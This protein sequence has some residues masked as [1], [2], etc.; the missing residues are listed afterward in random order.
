[1]SKKITS[2]DV[3]K[4]L[5]VSRSAVSRAF[6]EGASIHPEKRTLILEAAKALGYQ[7]NFFARN[8]S[9]P[10][11]KAKSNLIVILISDF[12]NPFQ[13]FLFE[14]L[15]TALQQAGKQ[16][17][18]LNVK[19]EQDL[20]E[21]ILRL[22]GYQVDGVIAVM[23]SLPAESLNRCLTLSMPLVTLG[24]A[25]TAGKIPS[26][27]TDNKMAGKLAAEH[28]LGQGCERVG[29]L[30]GRSDGQASIERWLGFSECIY[31]ELGIFPQVI[32]A[33]RYGYSA[34]FESAFKNLEALRELEGVFC[35]SDALALGVVDA[36][37][38][39]AGIEIPA[40]LRV[41]GCDNVPQ[42]AWQGYQLTTVAQPV[43][44]IAA[45]ALDALL[46]QGGGGAFE[47][48]IIRVQPTLKVRRT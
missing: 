7:P 12:S 2:S 15:S 8:L 46:K 11:Q 47:Q 20:D 40:K 22:S 24:R 44:E 39:F 14:E 9:T 28:L 37:Q 1:M 21:A 31:S 30:A 23:G 42:A 5:G 38:K 17:M 34:G 48:S 6:T 32:E 18:L 27:Q 35:A 3:A 41:V 43:K 45:K 4:Y 25:D 29:Y 13:S 33:G 26:V 36:C 10:T 19:E 16:P